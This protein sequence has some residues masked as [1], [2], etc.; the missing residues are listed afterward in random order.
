MDDGVA[1]MRK[2]GKDLDGDATMGEGTDLR[3]GKARE[4]G[5]GEEREGGG[6]RG[7]EGGGGEVMGQEGKQE[8]AVGRNWHSRLPLGFS[9]PTPAGVR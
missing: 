7:G 9:R 2:E 5:G 1:E 8:K 6:E 3:D 4:E